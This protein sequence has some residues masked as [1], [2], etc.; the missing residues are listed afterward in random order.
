M[1]G[2]FF[3]TSIRT[4]KILTLP[5]QSDEAVEYTDCI[6]AGSNTRPTSVTDMTINN[7]NNNNNNRKNFP[8]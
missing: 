4:N 2:W 6:S 3:L 1:I 7:N 8:G 5:A